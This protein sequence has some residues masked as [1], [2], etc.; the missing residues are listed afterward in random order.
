MSN[1]ISWEELK[2]KLDLARR[3]GKRI[4][5]CTGSFDLLHPGHISHFNAAKK[6]CDVLVVGIAKD[7]FSSRKREYKGRPIFSHDL[8]AYTVSNL[9]SVDYVILDDGSI[10]IVLFIKPEVYIKGSDYINSSI[11]SHIETKK[12]I[13]EYGGKVEYTN[14]EKLATTEIIE[15]IKREVK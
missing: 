13:E 11:S 3:E 5:L 6:L 10:D 2:I 1:L 15:Y 12:I 14:E 8:R 4:G 9:K 7:V